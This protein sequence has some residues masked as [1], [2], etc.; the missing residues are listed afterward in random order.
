MASCRSCL[1]VT[2]RRSP[3]TA[4]LR[5][6]FLPATP[7]PGKAGE[8]KLAAMLG[9]PMAGAK[10]FADGA[11]SG[12]IEDALERQRLFVAAQPQRGLDGFPLVAGI[13]AAVGGGR[14]LHQVE[15][16]LGVRLLHAHLA[17]DDRNR[18]RFH[19]TGVWM[20]FTR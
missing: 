5:G 9:L 13:D 7:E 14:A 1:K 16:L 20:A 2:E 19:R 10:I 6:L 12:K 3:M 11:H 18:A 17:H 4:N 8:V 15:I